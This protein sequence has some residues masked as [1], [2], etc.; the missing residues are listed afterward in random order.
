MAIN[1]Q[2][3][4]IIRT[5]I[6]DIQSNQNQESKR[7]EWDAYQ[8]TQGLQKNYVQQRLSEKYPKNFR[9]MTVSDISIGK[10]ITDKLAKA[11]STQPIRSIQTEV[12][13]V[14]E[15]FDNLYEAIDMNSYMKEF[16]SI[17]NLHKRALLW[18]DYN[19]AEQSFKLWPLR[20]YEYD[21]VRDPNTG[22]VLCVILNYP[23]DLITRQNLYIDSGDE[24]SDGINQLISES[25]F[26][27][28]AE[29]KVYAMWTDTQH[30]VVVVQK[31]TTK[32]A[33]GNEISYAI[34]YV[35]L[36]SNPEQINPLGMLPFVYKQQ[37]FSVDYPT[38][39]Q[40]TDQSITFNMIYSDVLTA[41][42]MQGYG[43]A[44]LKYPDN[45]EVREIEVGLMT[46][47]KL[48]QSTEPDA[49]PTEFK[50]EQA[51][52]DL[53]GHKDLALNYLQMI[54]SEHG[55]TS[56]QGISGG[57]EKFSSGLD[58]LLANADV[59]WKVEE[60][61]I[62]YKSV[63]SKSFDILKAWLELL[64]NNIFAQAGKFKIYFPK[65]TIQITDGEKLDNIKKVLDM[66]IKDRVD[67]L[68]MFDPNL[69]KQQAE[70]QIAAIDAKSQESMKSF[71]NPTA[72][73]T[74]QTEDEE[75]TQDIT[76][77]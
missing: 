3:I 49:P 1:L 12:E 59:S 51:S 52:P 47:I 60:N 63:E 28:G 65:P 15:E 73:N 54:L 35:P 43:Q 41:A 48:P 45:A 21:L 23:D 24:V 17:Y 71:F 62:V 25:Q 13:T 68:Q 46:A 27:S 31:K 11:Y 33:T 22:K 75:I 70:D 30:V 40:V 77:N 18:I 34:T 26:D 61:Q 36:P 74:D 16:D 5:I 56:D 39:N 4:N 58:R 53:A 29:S 76:V 69:T 66:R 72:Q 14:K 6:Q 8:C 10:K 32:T 44:T 19:L 20:P 55:I 50:Y 38:T 64:G 2:D 37:G 67:A 42:A 9:K 7:K 57:V